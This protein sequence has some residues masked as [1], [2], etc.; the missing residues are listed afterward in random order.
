MRAP[1]HYDKTNNVDIDLIKKQ[2]A[3][4]AAAINLIKEYPA[5]CKTPQEFAALQALINIVDQL[6]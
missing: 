5:T 6:K 4:L 1:M 2:E 3:L